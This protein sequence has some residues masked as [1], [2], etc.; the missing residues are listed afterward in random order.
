MTTW[1]ARE[2]VPADTKIRSL[3]HSLIA[4]FTVINAGFL[5]F[6][7]GV[8]IAAEAQMTGEGFHDLGVYLGREL[9]LQQ[10]YAWWMVSGLASA[11]GFA[12]L[13]GYLAKV[14]WAR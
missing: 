5:A 6:V 2:P 3:R 14:R 8:Y 11:V 10:V 7:I 13:Y 9:M 4:I 12:A 1:T